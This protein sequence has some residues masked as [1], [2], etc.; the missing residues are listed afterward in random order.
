MVGERYRDH[1][2][3]PARAEKRTVED[4]DPVSRGD[5]LWTS[6]RFSN[7]SILGQELASTSSGP[8]GSPDVVESFRCAADRIDLVDER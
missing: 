7:P 1:P 8:R 5:D 3:E 6:P 2:V 4:V